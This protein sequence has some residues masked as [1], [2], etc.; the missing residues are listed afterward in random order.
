[1]LISM[2]IHWIKKNKVHLKFFIG[3]LN[4]LISLWPMYLHKGEEVPLRLLS[5]ARTQYELKG[6][7]ISECMCV[8]PIKH[9]IHGRMG[10]FKSC[11]SHKQTHGIRRPKHVFHIK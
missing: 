10:S 9:E 3:T 8:S 4:Q 7:S 2:I 6:S 1:M 11:W 5:S